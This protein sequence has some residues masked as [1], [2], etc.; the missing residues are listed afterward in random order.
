VPGSARAAPT[1]GIAWAHRIVFRRLWAGNRRFSEPR[2]S[3]SD[4]PSS[5]YL[6]SAT[7]NF[8]FESN[9]AGTASVIH[10]GAVLRQALTVQGAAPLVFGDYDERRC[11][12]GPWS[13]VSRIRLSRIRLSPDLERCRFSLG[14]K[15]HLVRIATC[16]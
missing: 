8:L 7:C 16:S 3:N 11:V 15:L 1:F 2:E 14:R 4:T 9:G 13:A 12:E 5:P 6:I 10:V